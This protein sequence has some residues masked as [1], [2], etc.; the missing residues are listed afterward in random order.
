MNWCGKS[1]KRGKLFRAGSKR[2][3][4]GI[5]YQR[6]SLLDLRSARAMGL[7]LK[8]RSS[9]FPRSRGILPLI[10]WEPSFL[11]ELVVLREK[12][13]LRRSNCRKFAIFS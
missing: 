11:R 1:F 8:I 6:F 9:P 5:R 4:I 2:R 7:F 3:M 13:V 12:G 10:L